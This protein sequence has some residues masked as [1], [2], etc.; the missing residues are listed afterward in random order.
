MPSSPLRVAVVCMSNVNRSME[1]HHILS[2]NGFH[3]RSFGARSHVRLP[4]GAHKPPVR[5][6]FSTPYKKMHSDLSSKDQKLY[7]RNGVLHILKRNERIKPGPERFQECPDPFDIIFTCGQR[8]YNRVVADLCARDQET[9]Q[10]V[11]VV[12][13]DIDDTLEAASLGASIICTPHPVKEVE[14]ERIAWH[15]EHGTLVDMPT[16][17]MWGTTVWNWTWKEELS[18]HRV[19]QRC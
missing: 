19:L 11:L 14:E 18:A 9:W 16:L 2:K 10:P 12:N 13:V 8:A 6:N 17:P 3:V 7:K 4:G 1:A 5:Y 15:G